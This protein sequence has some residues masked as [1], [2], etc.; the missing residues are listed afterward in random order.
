[1]TKVRL[2]ERGRPAFT[3]IELLV[4]VVI[5]GIVAALVIARFS[6]IRERVYIDAMMNDLR[7]FALA[8]E[9]YRAETGRYGSPAEL[10]QSGWAYSAD[11]AEATVDTD[12]VDRY[13]FQV[14]HAKTD[15]RCDIDYGT[16][17]PNRIRSPSTP[18]E[19]EEPGSLQPNQPPVASFVVEPQRPVRGRV[20][21][22]DALDSSDPEG[23][24]LTYLWQIAPEGGLDAAPVQEYATPGET[25][26]LRTGTKKKPPGTRKSRVAEW[27]RR[28]S[29]PRPRIDPSVRLRA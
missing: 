20:A 3:L 26:T 14:R 22:L 5:M 11:V 29:N 27:S 16:G 13:F 2:P 17:R 28:E 8:T 12:F 25:P 1:M 19:E 24:A 21:V 10:L 23:E 15:T 4:V 9:Q 7:N 6:D 18:G